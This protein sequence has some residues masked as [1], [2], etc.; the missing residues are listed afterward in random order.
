MRT[1][2]LI[3][4]R[5]WE[6]MSKV[7]RNANFTLPVLGHALS[8]CGEAPLGAAYDALLRYLDIQ[9]SAPLIIIV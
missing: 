8:V 9:L 1:G 2:L 7:L 3:S 5:A 6:M 4:R